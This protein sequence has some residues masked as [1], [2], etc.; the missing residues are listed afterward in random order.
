MRARTKISCIQNPTF[1][2]SDRSGY[3]KIMRPLLTLLAIAD[4]LYGMCI[5]SQ[6]IIHYQT[7]HNFRES[8]SDEIVEF[9]DFLLGPDN[10][11][12]FYTN[13]LGCVR[14]SAVKANVTLVFCITT[15]RMCLTCFPLQSV[16]Q[17]CK[18]TTKHNIALTLTVI[19]ISVMLNKNMYKITRIS[20]CYGML[21]CEA[22]DSFSCSKRSVITACI[23]IILCILILTMIIKTWVLAVRKNKEAEKLRILSR[24]RN[25][26]NFKAVKV[27]L[28]ISLIFL[29]SNS[30]PSLNNAVK[31]VCGITPYFGSSLDQ[32]YHVGDILEQW[33]L[34]LMTVFNCIVYTATNKSVRKFSMLYYKLTLLRS[35]YQEPPEVEVV[36]YSVKVDMVELKRTSVRV[37]AMTNW[38]DELRRGFANMSN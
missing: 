20:K 5:T 26:M 8:R 4:L 28:G 33:L 22:L 9:S 19:A 18:Y 21:M 14:Q 35:C 6:V 31:L 27:S 12:K 2:F 36:N 13:V 29:V 10:H 16:R 32:V 17:F 7:L 23:S 11:L 1:Y 34:P 25:S 38:K 3:Y 24:H 15:V 30:G 37:T